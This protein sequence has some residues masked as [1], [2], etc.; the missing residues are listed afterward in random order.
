MKPLIL[1]FKAIIFLA[2]VGLVVFLVTD[3]HPVIFES[4]ESKNDQGGPVFNQIQFFST[5]KNDIWMM[6]QSHHGPTT[7]VNKWDRLAIVIDKTQSPPTARF[8]QLEPGPLVWSQTPATK[9]F[10]VSCFMCH[11]NG[12]RLIRPNDH[13]QLTAMGLFDTVKIFFL[14]FKIRSYQR[15][16]LDP[17]HLQKNE[18]TKIPFRWSGKYENE[19]LEVKAC[20]KCHQE[21]GLKSR[22]K[23]SRQQSPTIRFMLESGLMPPPGHSLT[24]AEQQQL[25][26]FLAGF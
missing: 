12:P 21:Q 20:T 13:S 18:S 24:Q 6:N 10:R 26:R 9:D 25:E 22:G 4:L 1:S 7:E 2:I 8:Y 16:A 19:F 11:N 17:I 3:D 5:D 23:L 14:N 15:I